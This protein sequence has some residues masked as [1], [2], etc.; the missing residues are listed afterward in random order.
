MARK[1]KLI[2]NNC[3]NFTKL[4]KKMFDQKKLA[5]YKIYHYEEHFK[6]S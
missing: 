3:K 6:I 2:T 4:K 1:L 5:W